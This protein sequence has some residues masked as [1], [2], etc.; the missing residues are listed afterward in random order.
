MR[1]D[2]LRLIRRFSGGVDRRQSVEWGKKETKN[3]GGGKKKKIYERKVE[4]MLL[5]HSDFHRG[6]SSMGHR[7]GP[8]GGK[9]V[10][11]GKE[12]GAYRKKRA[13]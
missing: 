5:L 6:H 12:K 13:G 3:Q 1:L 7:G 8:L 2:G 4:T 10:L 11:G 9:T